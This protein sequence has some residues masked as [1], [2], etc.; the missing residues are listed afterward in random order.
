MTNSIHSVGT[1][2]KTTSVNRI[3]DAIH[4][5]RQIH[6]IARSNSRKIHPRQIH[7]LA[8]RAADRLRRR[9]IHEVKT[10]KMVPVSQEEMAA[11]GL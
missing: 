11:W 7:K 1:C 6:K 9:I 5:P 3:G 4:N 10:G 8:S 2:L